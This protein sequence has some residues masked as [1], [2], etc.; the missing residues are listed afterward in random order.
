MRPPRGSVRY[1]GFRHLGFTLS[2]HS[3]RAYHGNGAC[4]H[5][6]RLGCHG[7]IGPSAS[8]D[9]DCGPLTRDPRDRPLW[10][11][12]PIFPYYSYKPLLYPVCFKV[13]LS[14]RSGSFSWI[15]YKLVF[16]LLKI[17][18]I[19]MFETLILTNHLKFRVTLMD[20]QD[21]LVRRRGEQKILKAVPPV[22]YFYGRLGGEIFSG[23][24]EIM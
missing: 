22:L 9:Q 7:N 24:S 19:E 1:L 12:S 5:G 20:H 10:R 16:S 11:R 23:P 6:K 2:Y 3:G 4:C 15:Q 17:C 14:I 18:H 13:G 8:R 21:L